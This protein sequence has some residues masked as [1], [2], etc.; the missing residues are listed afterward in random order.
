MNYIQKNGCSNIRESKH[1]VVV[2]KC[3]FLIEEDSGLEIA[4]TLYISM[5]L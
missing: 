2:L 1:C 3:H 4:N 5:E